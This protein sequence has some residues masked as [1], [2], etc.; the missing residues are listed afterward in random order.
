MIRL[1]AL[2]AVGCLLATAGL[3]CHAAADVGH[4]SANIG[5]A[6]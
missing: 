4:D 5:A 2:L 1:I 6:R 3:G